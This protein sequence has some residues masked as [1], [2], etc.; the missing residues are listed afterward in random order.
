VIASRYYVQ[1]S[2]TLATMV[3]NGIPLLNALRLMHAATANRHLHGVVGRAVEIVQEGKP[4]TSALQ[5]VGEFPPAFLDMVS[6]GEQTGDMAAAL[7]NVGN[8]Y[9]EELNIKI[10][11]VMSVIQPVM[12]GLMALAVGVVAYS[13]VTGIFQSVN[14]IGRH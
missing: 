10:Q 12:I 14:G 9:D 13:M 5:K 6:V 11:R 4:L 8:R 2:Q 3:G 7:E 1:F